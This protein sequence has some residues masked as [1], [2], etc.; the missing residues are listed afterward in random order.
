MLTLA[1]LI[2]LFAAIKGLILGFQKR[3]EPA[4]EV[5]YYDIYIID[6]RFNY[7]TINGWHK[8]GNFGET[9]LTHTF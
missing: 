6:E 2:F 7:P 4:R 3:N 5:P 8:T 1:F 9:N